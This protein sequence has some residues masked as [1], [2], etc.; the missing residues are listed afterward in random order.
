VANVLEGTV[1]RDRNHVR[2]STELVDA[3][4][5]NTIWADSYDRD[6]TDI[7]TIQSEIAQKV[8]SKLSAQLSPEERK[9]I[10]EKPT[11][12]LEAYD[13]Y[14]QAKQLLEAHY[15]VLPGNEMQIYSN[16]I[17]LL[18]EATRKD[19]KFALAYCLLTK[20]HD[21]LYVDRI[22][23]T[24]NRRAL[25]DAAVNEALR[26]RP[27]LAEVHLAM[28]FH[29]CY[30]YR[31]FERARVQIA[32]AAQSL[33]NNAEVLELTAGI[34]RLQGRWEKSTAGLEKAITLDPRSLE[35][36]GELWWNYM[37]LR[38]YRDER[39]IVDRQIEVDPNEP[40]YPVYKA[41]S[42][43]CEK[44]DVKGARAAYE[45]LPAAV[46]ND[47]FITIVRCFYAMCD[48][49][50][51]TA[52]EIVS[53]S[54]HE[55]IFFAGAIVPR[56]VADI[57]LDMVEGNQPSMEE[58]GE[59]REQLYQKVEADPTNPHL[60]SA[61]AYADVGLNRKKEAIEEG[62]RAL[63][64]RPISEDQVEGPGLAF[65][66]ALVY[67]WAGESDLAF[68]QLNILTEMPGP[69]TYG[70]LK[71]DPEWDPLRKDP[72]FDKLLAELAPRD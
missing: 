66:L 31:D 72:R 54:P 6:L 62:R 37:S 65:S 21:I 58:Y 64:M 47:I 22:D 40:M 3:R 20:A 39:R 34:D 63:E 43:F 4:D 17:S 11:D 44:A 14:L 26:L 50:F 45:A 57:W 51:K 53:Q 70:N 55:E 24:P 32:I 25:G 7:F 41:D 48:R 33:P 8:A 19:S 38:R 9:D 60:L 5:D 27:D 13:L 71:T 42:F 61:L 1:R 56:R 23:H 46:K 59:T 12:N 67:T 69:I 18:E 35:R 28:A 2:V 16:I 52:H 29:L 68:E 30:S 36:L 49:D 10:E 15:W